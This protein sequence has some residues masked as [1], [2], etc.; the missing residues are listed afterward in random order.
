[1]TSQMMVAMEGGNRFEF[2]FGF[3]F[4]PVILEFLVF[5]TFRP[6]CFS[7]FLLLGSDFLCFFALSTPY[8]SYIRMR[9]CIS[10]CL[11]SIGQ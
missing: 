2:G 8:C 4:L 11:N 3:Y 1:M 5:L 10:R 7:A 6:L 9:E